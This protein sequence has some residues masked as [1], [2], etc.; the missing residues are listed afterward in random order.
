MSGQAPRTDVGEVLLELPGSGR[1]LFT[2]RAAGNL[3]TGMGDGHEHG[4]RRR[5]ELCE[6]HDLRWV[7]S[8]HQVHGTV[9]HVIDR[10]TGSGGEPVALE[11][12]GHVTA[13][14]GV[15][16]M[17]M[18]AD[19]LAVALGTESAVAMVHAGW[20]GLAAGALEQ[21]VRALRELAGGESIEAIAGPCAGVC[22]YEVGPEVHAA[23]GG[24]RRADGNLDLR[25]IA[26]ERLRD[27]GI[28]HVRDVEV[29]TICDER[30][31]SYRREGANAGRQAGV[32][33]LN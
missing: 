24:A 16:A 15:G 23:F 2:S 8:S 29:C 13:L 3:S 12:D 1:A 10:E 17:V 33:W 31:F 21:G 9:M 28:G 11:A 25:A 7:C 4:I 22:C 5:E 19:C 20:R 26:H 27:A 32:A 14:T 6:H 30:F 18:A